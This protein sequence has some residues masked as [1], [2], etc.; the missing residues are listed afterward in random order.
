VILATD[1]PLAVEATAAIE[2]GDVDR[3]QLGGLG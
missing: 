2:A 3:H 1:D